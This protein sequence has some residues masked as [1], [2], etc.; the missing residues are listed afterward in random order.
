MKKRKSKTYPDWRA[1]QD[2]VADF[3][4]TQGYGAETEARLSGVRSEHKIDVL[5]TFE[6]D[7]IPCKWIIECKYWRSKV[8]KEKVETLKSIVNE[9]GADRGIM[10][11]EKGFQSGAYEAAGNANLSLFSSLSEFK[12]TALLSKTH[13]SLIAE[14]TENGLHAF[15]FSYNAM[16]SEVLTYKNMLITA[17]WGSGSIS[18]IDPSSKI[19]LKNIELD[20]YQFNNRT[21]GKKEIRRYPPGSL[22]VA[23]GKLFIGQVFSEFI[24]CIDFETQAIIKR[25]NIPGGGEGQ[26]TAAADGSFVIFASNKLSQFYIID[27]A[28]YEYRSVAYPSPGRGCLSIQIHSFNKYVYIGIQRGG[29]HGGPFLAIYDLGLSKYT[30]TIDLSVD[31]SDSSAD[32]MPICIS[33]DQSTNRLFIGMMQSVAGIYVIDT[34]KYE[35]IKHIAFEANEYNKDFPWVDPISQ[36]IVGNTLF[37]VNRNNCELVTLHLDSLKVIGHHFVGVAPNGPRSVTVIGEY[38]VVTYPGRNMLLF[39]SLRE[40]IQV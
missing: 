4:R 23:D 5:V 15:R 20:N 24:L 35:I 27:A 9:V 30:A 16:P 12:R 2:D 40:L 11:S 33:L 19:I 18:I 17:N 14:G 26:L 28:T 38:I 37:S 39:G 32:G 7:G 34:E 10:F 36:A 6:K 1:Y 13:Y 21:T 22:A 25:L 3:F 29:R 31:Q 8:P